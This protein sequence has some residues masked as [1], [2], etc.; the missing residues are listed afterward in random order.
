MIK[1]LIIVLACVGS[2]MSSAHAETWRMSV[3][4]IDQWSHFH[5]PTTVTNRFWH[6]TLEGDRLSA[7]GP[8]GLA[9]ATTV[10]SGGNFKASFKGTWHGDP[11]EAEV[12]GNAKTRWAIQ[13]VAK[14][15][16][17]F[18]LTAVTP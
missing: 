7:S 8:D 12:S 3:E 17:W 16:C 9:W 1:K 15:G 18:R 6:Y 10:D 13:H 2:A 11:F 4:L 5:C 14:E